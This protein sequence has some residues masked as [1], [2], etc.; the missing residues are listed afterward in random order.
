MNREAAEKKLK[1]N[2][3]FIFARSINVDNKNFTAYRLNVVEVG[4]NNYDVVVHLSPNIPSITPMPMDKF[5]SYSEW[6]KH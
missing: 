2:Y 5:L 1:D 4:S 3:N 6:N